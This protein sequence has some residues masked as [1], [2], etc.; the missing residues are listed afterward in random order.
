MHEVARILEVSQMHAYE[1]A[2]FYTMFNSQSVGEDIR[3]LMKVI[4]FIEL[5]VV[6]GMISTL[7]VIAV[8]K[9]MRETIVWDCEDPPGVALFDEFAVS[10][11]SELCSELARTMYLEE[12]RF[13]LIAGTLQYCLNM[14]QPDRSGELGSSVALHYSSK[15]CRY[16]RG[17]S[18]APLNASLIGE[19]VAGVNKKMLKQGRGRNGYEQLKEGEIETFPDFEDRMR[20]FVSL[21]DFRNSTKLEAYIRS[22]TEA[23]HVRGVP[24]LAIDSSQLKDVG[25]NYWNEGGMVSD[26]RGQNYCFPGEPS[27]SPLIFAILNRTD[28]NV[29]KKN[30]KLSHEQSAR[31]LKSMM[32]ELKSNIAKFKAS[33]SL[34]AVH[35]MNNLMNKVME[36][37]H[38]EKG[39]TNSFTPFIA[40]KNNLIT[41]A[42]SGDGGLSSISMGIPRMLYTI[43]RHSFYGENLEDAITAPLLYPHPFR[44]NA[45]FSY[46]YPLRSKLAKSYLRSSDIVDV[47]SYFSDT[48]AAVSRRYGY[49]L[50]QTDKGEKQLPHQPTKHLVH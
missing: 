40:V 2:T 22:R 42:Y 37:F 47:P 19:F 21:L 3:V 44:E 28:Y 20:H 18:R 31:L 12:Y 11:S 16:T 13:D 35:F 23:Q 49:E 38:A 1:I 17:E 10:S 24:P 46:N 50:W 4:I 7:Y 5:I 9:V 26:G 8:K 14:Q 15:G 29:M 41:V 25:N 33:G 34:Y 45:A 27:V 36:H 6:F 30:D 48:V 43:L 32:L 39:F